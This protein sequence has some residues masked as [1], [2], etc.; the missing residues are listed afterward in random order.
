MYSLF[1]VSISIV[2]RFILQFR[3]R[4]RTALKLKKQPKQRKHKHKQEQQESSWE[5]R[6]QDHTRQ[7]SSLM[8]STLTSDQ[9]TSKVAIVLDKMSRNPIPQQGQYF[10]TI[11]EKCFYTESGKTFLL[12]KQFATQ[13]STCPQQAEYEHA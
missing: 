13:P 9:Y 7:Y 1:S 2:T 11:K 4:L 12:Y 3:R 5:N 8:I 10:R 6:S